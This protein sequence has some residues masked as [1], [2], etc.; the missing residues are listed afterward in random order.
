RLKLKSR[1]YFVVSLHREENIDSKENFDALLNSLE[2]LAGVYNKR[3]IFSTHPRTRKKLE[4]INYQ[5]DKIEFMKPLGFFDYIAL[6]KNSFCT[7][8]DSGTITEESALLKFPA[9]TVRQAHER[10][11]GMDKTSILMSALEFSSLQKS[12]SLATTMDFVSEG[13]EDYSALDVSKKV[14]RIVHSYVDFVNHTIWKK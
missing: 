2:Q 5:N 6:Q 3:I 7:I 10:P 9:I 14:V 12:V 1:E 4:S 11:E 8:S 13:I